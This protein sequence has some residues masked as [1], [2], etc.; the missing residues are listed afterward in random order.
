MSIG[1]WSTTDF[2]TVATLLYEQY[3]VINI[4]DEKDKGKIKR[5]HF[6]DSSDLHDTV[7]KYINGQLVGN[8]RDFKNAIEQVK[9]MIHSR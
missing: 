4:T 8:L 7:R 9:D 5:F 3:E 6:A 1:S 2:Y